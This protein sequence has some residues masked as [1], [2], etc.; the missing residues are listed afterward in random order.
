MAPVTTK[1]TKPPGARTLTGQTA[2]VEM[3]ETTTE[4]LA[5]ESSGLSMSDVG[6]RF[7]L[8]T[9]DQRTLKGRVFGMFG[10]A[11]EH[12]DF[13]AIRNFSLQVRKGDVLGIM[14]SNGSGKSTLLRVM[15]R[16]IPPTEGKVEVRGEISP[17]LELGGAFNAELTGREN[18]FLQG[19]LHKISRE[20]MAGLMS[21]IQAFADIGPFFDVPMKTY[22]TGMVSRLGFAVSIQMQPDILLIDEVFSVGDENFQRK[23]AIRM[24]KLIDKGVIVVI[25]SHGA[26]I[27]RQVC[28]RAIWLDRG[29][30]MEDGKPAQVTESYLRHASR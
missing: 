25:V 28:N 29:G 1:L 8:L 6:V 2:V 27:I 12:A 30:L 9:E 7:R 14:G 5:Y 17:M 4:G 23:S 19:A 20:E 18:A 21:E 16:V 22:S 26:G 10:G 3:A 15:S 24:R 13:W 11:P